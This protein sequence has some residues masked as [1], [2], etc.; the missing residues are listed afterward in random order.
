MGIVVDHPAAALMAEV[1]A[2]RAIVETPEATAL[3]RAIFKAVSDYWDYLDGHG[4]MYDCERD[5][6]R[7]SA[8]H[9]THDVN[10]CEIA[11]KD[12]AIDRRYGDGEDPDPWGRGLN[13]TWPNPTRLRP[14]NPTW[15][16]PL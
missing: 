12:G 11:L 6:M 3:I 4:L 8:L 16:R 15:P 7:A 5:L 14:P 1:R 2:E 13:P 9:I 10:G